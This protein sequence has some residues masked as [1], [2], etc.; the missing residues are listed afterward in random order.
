[1]TS[2]PPERPPEDPPLPPR[3]EADPPPPPSAAQLRARALA[4]AKQLERDRALHER[5]RVAHDNGLI[6]FY[7][8][9][10][11]LNRGGSPVFSVTD[12]MVPLLSLLLISV[13]LLF[14]SI[15]AG[16]GA[17]IFTSI[18]YL[19]LLR[20]WIAR[21]LRERTIRKMMESPHN[22]TVLWQFG[23]IVITLASN[24]RIGCAAP[25]SDWRAIARN[26]VAQAQGPGLGIDEHDA[27]PFTD[28]P[29]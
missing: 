15:F 23:G 14:V 12:N 19:F 1:M 18:A 9:F 17:L 16:L 10:H 6:T 2:P 11:H 21:R 26:F 25:G 22:W 28:G 7:T 8:N 20:P 4:K 27:R 3:I 29:Q 5:M 24:P 13:G